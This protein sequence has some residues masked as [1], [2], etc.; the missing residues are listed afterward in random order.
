MNDRGNLFVLRLESCISSS[1]IMPLINIVTV[2][3]CI[4]IIVLYCIVYI[5]IMFYNF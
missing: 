3:Y 4:V 5:V 2:L 1:L